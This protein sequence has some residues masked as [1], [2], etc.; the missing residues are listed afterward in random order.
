MLVGYTAQRSVNITKAWITGDFTARSRNISS[1]PPQRFSKA[2]KYIN[3][4]SASCSKGKHN[5]SCHKL[6]CPCD[7]HAQY[8]I[9]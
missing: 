5:T 2:K 3:T 7:C 8:T 6:D 9:R 1:T 4:V